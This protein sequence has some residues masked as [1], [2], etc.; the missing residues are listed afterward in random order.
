MSL[1]KQDL[2]DFEDEIAAAF[3]NK[4]IR[5]PVHLNNGDEDQLIEVFN[6]YN[7]SQD[8]WAFS[9]WR[10]H[11]ISL[12]K[13]IPKERLK[14]DIIKGK[15]ISLCYPEYNIFSSAIVGGSI[16]ISVGTAAGL[17]KQGKS[18]RVFCFLGDMAAETGT[19]S[20]CYNYSMRFN[21]PIVFVIG[22]NN[23]SVCTPT[24]KVCYGNND[25]LTSPE[26]YS[27]ANNYYDSKIYYYKFESKYPHSG[28]GG[29][30][31]VF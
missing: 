14:S 31:I 4:L 25:A 28:I 20:E 6:K 12:L 18:G 5:A 19:F 7:I 2:I 24:R 23:K 17:K 22:D 10:S 15:S 29:Q 16:S 9:T 3:N 13:G 30:R 1:S 21:L 26:V 11:Y 8:D 27:K